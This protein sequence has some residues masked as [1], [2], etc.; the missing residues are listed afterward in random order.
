MA[1]QIN[2]RLP[3][4]TDD[5]RKKRL[6][7]KERQFDEEKRRK[8]LEEY[9]REKQKEKE[10][11][12]PVIDESGSTHQAVR[13]TDVHSRFA[14][15]K[16]RLSETGSRFREGFISISQDLKRAGSYKLREK[17][18]KLTEEER[19]EKIEKLKSKTEVLNAE[20][21]YLNA[22]ARIEKLNKQR[23]SDILQGSIF[24]LDPLTWYGM[25]GMKA[26]DERSWYGLS[27]QNK[28]AA[29]MAFNPD[30]YNAIFNN[31]GSSGFSSKK[32]KAWDGNI[33]NMGGP[34]FGMNPPDMRKL[35]KFYG[36]G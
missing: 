9:E 18:G 36:M 8:F 5:E 15:V 35:K 6:L 30:A 1:K 32:S 24:T 21:R 11:S 29:G 17:T 4:E 33:L 27:G 10:N 25:S 28:N 34:S 19:R 12:K 2:S 20:S 13:K 23:S 3:E 14:D 26:L 31:Y 22:E 16:E 7:Q